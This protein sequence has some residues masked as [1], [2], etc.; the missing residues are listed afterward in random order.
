M[1][2]VRTKFAHGLRYDPVSLNGYIMYSMSIWLFL[3]GVCYRGMILARAALPLC[4]WSSEDGSWQDALILAQ[5]V[6]INSPSASPLAFL[7]IYERWRV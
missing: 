5:F 6:A 2:D 7:Q 1:M 3:D 4:L